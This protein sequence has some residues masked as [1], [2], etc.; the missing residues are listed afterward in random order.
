MVGYRRLDVLL[1]VLWR[2]NLGMVNWERAAWSTLR[3]KVIM[4]RCA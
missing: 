3:H 1:L 2:E 4:R